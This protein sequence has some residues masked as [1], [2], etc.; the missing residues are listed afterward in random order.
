MKKLAV[1]ILICGMG[2]GAAYMSLSCSPSKNPAAPGFQDPVSTLIPLNPSFTPTNTF[3]ATATTTATPT[4]TPTPTH[5]PFA[6]A[7]V[8]GL[9][10]PEG[11]ALDSS[12]ALYV[13]DTGN[14]LVKKYVNGRLD[15]SWG[16]HGGGEIPFANP[17]GVAVD[18][19]GLLYVVGS[20]TDGVLQYDNQGHFKAQWSGFSGPEGVAVDS[21][22]NVYVSDT[23]NSRIVKLDSTGALVGAFGSGGAVALGMAGYGIAVDGSGNVAVACADNYVRVFDSVGGPSPV[24]IPGFSGP[25]GLA[26]DPEGDLYVADSGN[27]SIEEFLGGAGLKN[28]PAIFN[29]GKNLV[30]PMGVALDSNGTIYVADSGKNNVVIFTP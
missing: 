12:N 4:V 5:T 13:A 15:A 29:D 3:T 10:G 20:G 6:T 26:F 28:A 27:K 1:F 30:S 25:R 16:P 7:T 21:S 2:L 24:L 19:N 9:S 22:D 11:L 14:N 8:T 18:G 23:G 17:Q